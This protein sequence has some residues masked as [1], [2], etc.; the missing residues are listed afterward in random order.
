MAHCHSLL[1]S[2]STTDDCQPEHPAVLDGEGQVRVV[3]DGHQVTIF[4]FVFQQKLLLRIKHSPEDSLHHEDQLIIGQVI[5]VYGDPPDVI[6][7]AGLD[8]DLPCHIQIVH[9]I[10]QGHDL[11]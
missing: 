10:L 1:L 6:P 9:A 11:L 7:Q 4:I 8:D 5:I 2:L 3:H